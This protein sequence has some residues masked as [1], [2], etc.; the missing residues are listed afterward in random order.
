[1]KSGFPQAG[2]TDKLYRRIL[3]LEQALEIKE[4]ENQ[5]LKD[6]LKDTAVHDKGDFKNLG[7]QANITDRTYSKEA[8]KNPASPANLFENPFMGMFRTDATTGEILE[9]NSKTWEMFG[10]KPAKG[11]TTTQF[12]LN[13]GDRKKVLAPLFE[14]MTVENVEVQ[15]K[16]AD[17]TEFWVSFSGVYHQ[18][19]NIIECVLIDITSRKENLL[20]LQRLNFE[21]DNFVFHASHDLR[22]PLRSILGLVEILRMNPDKATLDNCIE[23]IENSVHRLDRFVVDLL[24]LS[25]NNRVDDLYTPI[26]FAV[27]LNS[28][29]ASFYNV[30][31]TQNLEVITK[32]RQP[33]PFISDV[34]R[35]RI[36]LNNL[37][38]NAIKYR[39]YHKERSYIAIEIKV[40]PQKAVITIEDN[41]EGIPKDKV[42][43]VF[44]MFVR[45]SES[46]NGSGLGLYIVKNVLAKMDGNITLT[47]EYS[48]GTTFTLEIPNRG[49]AA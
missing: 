40:T 35:L 36:I 24:S 14:K 20:E 23:M 47:S 13:P 32:I 22:S 39:S 16:K 9:A 18:E 41:G 17:G 26:N 8:L 31:A 34:T 46:S 38:S 21:L 37:I 44:D 3:E 43:T 4:A 42:N 45:A 6:H 11:I 30:A 19:E 12:Y 25:R 7:P 48:K 33:V 27:E 5:E 2:Q 15:L 29:L 1:M 28:S 49:T 10:L